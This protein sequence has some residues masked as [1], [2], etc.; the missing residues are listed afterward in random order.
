MSRPITKVLGWSTIALGQWLLSGCSRAPSVFDPR[1]PAAAEI[2]RLGW[3]LIISGL[4]IYGGVCG[5]LLWALWRRSGAQDNGTVGEADRGQ[6][7]ILWGGIAMPSV[8]LLTIFGFT[9]NSLI[10]LSKPQSADELTINVIGHQWWWEVEY[11]DAGVIT[12]NEIHIPVGQPVRLNL[13]AEGVI[14][15]FWV[16]QLHGK[17]DLI[18]GQ[19]NSFRIQ[20]DQPGEYRGL[21]AEFCGI[22]HAKMLFLVVADPPETFAAWLERERLPANSPVGEAAQ[23]GEAIFLD[24]TC[25]QC[26][27]IAGTPAAGRLGPDLT[28]F[29][30]RREI[31]AGILENN[32]N[33]L[34]AWIVNSQEFKPGN[35]MPATEINETDLAAL[36]TY[37]ESLE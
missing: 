22:Q 3:L 18:P 31:G 25:A 19:V 27:A 30:S 23:Q 24:S 16:P 21:C 15:S 8:V 37:L 28:H 7:I 11:P 32:R 6:G 13:R 26:H 10:I 9:L 36:V 17:M 4:L 2:G 35:L 20:A 34:R 5:F 14:H 29:A 33:N 1:G 12:A